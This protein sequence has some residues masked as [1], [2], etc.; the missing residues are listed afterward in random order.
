MQTFLSHRFANINAT[1]AI[2]ETAG[3]VVSQ[4]NNHNEQQ[5]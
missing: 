5:I 2:I 1:I 3:F 4:H